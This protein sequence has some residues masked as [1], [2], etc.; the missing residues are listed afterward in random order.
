MFS[1]QFPREIATPKRKLVRTLNEYLRVINKNNGCNNLYTNVYNFETFNGW[2]PVYDTAIVDRIYLDFDP[3]MIHEDGSVTLRPEN[4]YY[5]FIEVFKWCREHGYHIYP[6]VSGS[7]YHVYIKVTCHDDIVNSKAL[8]LNMQKSIIDEVNKSL[9]AKLEEK[10]IKYDR[11]ITGEEFEKEWEQIKVVADTKVMGK[12]DQISRIPFTI[13][14]KCN[15][16]CIPIMPDIIY[17][18]DTIIKKLASDINYVR[19]LMGT[20]FNGYGEKLY[21]GTTMNTGRAL[22]ME[23]M[24][25]PI[26][27]DEPLKD[28]GLR[29]NVPQCL[30]WIFTQEVLG[31]DMRRIEIVWLKDNAYL[32]DEVKSILYKQ[33]TRPRRHGMYMQTDYEHLMHEGQVDYIFKRD[34]LFFPTHDKLRVM[35]L[36]PYE[37]NGACVLSKRGCRMYNRR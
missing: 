2:Q 12:V 3:K 24:Y 14:M 27:D 33:L 4:G 10:C 11:L 23:G 31:W 26:G 25:I 7:G 1:L 5:D 36:C 6:Y 17:E 29:E 30:R 16:Y 13:N 37:D 15:R 21:D 32:M 19:K 8:I 35:G 9:K 20:K 34:N 28:V 18:R 22:H